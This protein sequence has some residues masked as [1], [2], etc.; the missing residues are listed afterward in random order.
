[1]HNWFLYLSGQFP[2]PWFSRVPHMC[3]S[4][5]FWIISCVLKPYQEVFH[6]VTCSSYVS[7]YTI[8]DNQ[9]CSQTLPGGISHSNLFLICVPVYHSG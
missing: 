7:Q 8:L 1:M 2:S 9:L 3:P 4:I 5:P 6:T